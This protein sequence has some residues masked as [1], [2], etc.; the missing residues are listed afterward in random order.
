MVTFDNHSRRKVL[1][2]AG[3]GIGAGLAGCVGSMTGDGQES[4]P[5]NIHTM[6]TEGGITVATFLYAIN[7]NVWEPHG[8]NLS[9]E[10]ASFS[11]YNQQVVNNQSEIGA[12]S[13]VA[14]IQF[15]NEG[16]DLA[17]VGE[18]LSM[19]NRM[20]TRADEDDI[21]DPTDLS[22]KTLGLPAA[23]SS[24][25]SV[26]HRALINDEYDFDIVDDTAETIASPPPTLWEL[27]QNG[28]V[29]AISEFSGYTIRGIASDE[30]K[31]I[32]DP[33]EYWVNRTGVGLPTTNY[34]V[35]RSWLE[36]NVE[37]TQNFL[38]GW[39]D[40]MELME[41]E[42]DQAL[43][44]YGT[45]SGV[46]SDAQAETVKN[47]LNEGVIYGPAYLDEERIESTWEFLQI[48]Q[49]VGHFDQLPDKNELFITQSELEDMV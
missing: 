32:F 8:I 47:L 45:L 12:P 7:N 13:T 30:V 22:D 28:E 36:N 25:T 43:Q 49:D 14:Q 3:A 6:E 18:Q 40:A 37:T 20:F 16:E 2:A 41:N 23:L 1:T 5:T 27:L 34:T 46:T 33:Y 39:Q 10:V 17:F 19:Y 21:E 29:D 9:F 35:R 11:K 42:A 26:T 15:A 44:N 24:T 38:N 31:T 4:D 48:L